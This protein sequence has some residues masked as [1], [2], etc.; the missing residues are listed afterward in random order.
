VGVSVDEA[1][2]ILDQQLANTIHLARYT[3]GHIYA[4]VLDEPSIVWNRAFLESLDL[5]RLS[6]DPE[7]ML[8]D[9]SPHAGATE[10]YPWP[11]GWNPEAAFRFNTPR[12]TPAPALSTETV[13]PTDAAWTTTLR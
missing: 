6:F 3:A 8:A 10:R 9:Y 4:L 11:A 2:T 13:P 7:R 5:E 1:R 12:R